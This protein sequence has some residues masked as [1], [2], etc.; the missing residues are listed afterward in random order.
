MNIRQAEEKDVKSIIEIISLLKLDIPGFVWDDEK[1]ILDQI[2][3]GE[4]FV[5]EES[6]QVV[7]IISLRKRKNKVSIETLAVRKDFQHKGMGSELI[8]FAKKFTKEKG[9]DTLHA[10]SFTEYDAV[11]FYLNRNFKMMDN[12]GY[13]K[14]HK[15][16]CFEIK[17]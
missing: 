14:G 15:Y 17:V 8:E 12:S 6:G 9:F 13:Y 10:Y 16:D 4:Y 11:Q 5:L 3:K 1:F 7:A 2:K